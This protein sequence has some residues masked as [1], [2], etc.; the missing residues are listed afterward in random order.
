[1]EG[2]SE[3]LT[4]LSDISVID[5]ATFISALSTVVIAALTYSV[6]QENRKLRQSGS[7]PRL[8]VYFEPHPDGT[9]GLNIAIANHGSGPAK[10]VFITFKGIDSNFANKKLKLDISQKRGPFTFI[11]QGEKISVLFAIGYELFGEEDEKVKTP[12]MQPF[13]VFIEWNDLFRKKCYSEKYILD[14]KPYGDL[15]GFVNKPHL[16]RVVDSIN[17]VSRN[18]YKFNKDV[19]VLTNIIEA[20]KLDHSMVQKH[21]GN[22]ERKTC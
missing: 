18:I 4:F 19:T 15:P 22:V 21:I 5:I 8:L 17:T 14:V 3:I 9:G 10:D 6:L 20:N 2:F 1:M 7:E 16:L 11:P 12:L 13:E